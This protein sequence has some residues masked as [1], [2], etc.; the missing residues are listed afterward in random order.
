MKDFDSWNIEKQRADE[1][2]KFFN[3]KKRDIWW[4]SLGVN[5]GD[6]Q[7]GKGDKFLRPVLVYKKFSH[8][9][10]WAIPLTSKQKNNVFHFNFQ[11]NSKPQA[12][13]LSQIRLLD[14]K[15]LVRKLGVISTQDFLSLEKALQ[16]LMKR[17]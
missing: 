17:F 5:I 6:E 4:V 15:R 16:R 13:I 11:A 14:R 2:I 10:F 9:L 12:A 7:C 3:F 1:K 8:D